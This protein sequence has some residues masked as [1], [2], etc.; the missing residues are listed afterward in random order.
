MEAAADGSGRV[1]PQKSQQSPSGGCSPL[2]HG[3]AAPLGAPE[4]A[5]VAPAMLC[6]PAVCFSPAPAVRFLTG[7]VLPRPCPSLGGGTGC[8]KSSQMLG[9][10]RSPMKQGH[11]CFQ[12][13]NSMQNI[14]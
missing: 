4:D 3:A 1:L 10:N 11:S 6:S 5:A 12:I 14:K 13:L 8:K 7:S 2:D 9:R